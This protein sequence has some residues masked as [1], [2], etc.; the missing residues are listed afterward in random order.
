MYDDGC[1]LDKAS[2][3]DRRHAMCYGAPKLYVGGKTM[4]QVNPLA[5][6]PAGPGL[7]V[8]IPRLITAYYKGSP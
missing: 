8:N 1:I 5:G 4:V 2:N 3:A 7:L 6:K